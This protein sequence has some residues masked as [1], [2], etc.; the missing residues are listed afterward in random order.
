MIRVETVS[1]RFGDVVAVDEASFEARDGLV[2]GILGPNGAGKSTTLRMIYGLLRPYGGRI[3]VD[4]ISVAGNPLEAQARM[5]ALPDVSGL[6][7]RLTSREQIEYFGQ[8]RGL[9]SKQIEANVQYWTGA[10]GMEGIIQRRTA[11]APKS[12]S[13]AR[14]CIAPRT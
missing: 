2:T 13:P 9:S 12:P 1:K 10:L 3:D 8:L 5:G 14:S 7:A 4:G 11:S 6:Y